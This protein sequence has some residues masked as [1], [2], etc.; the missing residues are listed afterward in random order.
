MIDVSIEFLLTALQ[1]TMLAAWRA[2]PLF[3]IVLVIDLLFQRRIAPRFHCLLWMLVI[4]RMVCPV[5]F[6]TGFSLHRPIDNL[7]VSVG[8]ADP[9]VSQMP[10]HGGQTFGAQLRR[11]R[12]PAPWLVYSVTKTSRFGTS[13]ATSSCRR[14]WTPPSATD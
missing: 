13:T 4:A 10:S 8:L 2:L 9:P 7:M 5:S 12:I 14:C 1:W 3:V 11:V 6:G